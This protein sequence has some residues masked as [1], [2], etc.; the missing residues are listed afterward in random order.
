MRRR[1]QIGLI[2][3]V[4][5]LVLLA[6]LTPAQAQLKPGTVEVKRVTGQVEIQRRGQTTWARAAAA[7]QLA[8]GD[9]IRALAGASADLNYPDGSTVL[10]A[11]NSR[12][13]ITK[14]EYDAASGARNI[15]SHLSVGKIKAQVKSASVQLVRARQANFFVSTPVGVAAVRGTILVLM[16]NPTTNQVFVG[17]MPSPGQPPVQAVVQFAGFGPPGTPPVTVTISGGQFTTQVGTAAPSAPQPITTLPAIVQAGLATPSNPATANSPNLAGMVTV[18]VNIPPIPDTP[19]AVAAA[20]VVQIL[21]PPTTP[22]PVV[23]IGTDIIQICASPPC[24]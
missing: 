13:A 7:E 12:L 6:G 18:L 22:V 10:L 9:H 16:F 15:A 8:E 24:D 2:A 3:A 14:V 23:T 4:A 1:A 21:G 20:P 5:V 17:A 19:A 11:E